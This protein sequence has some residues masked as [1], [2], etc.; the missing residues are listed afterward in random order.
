M[1]DYSESGVGMEIKSE[2]DIQFKVGDTVTVVLRRNEIVHSFE[3]TVK[4][5][6]KNILGVKFN[7]E[8]LDSLRMLIQITFSRADAWEVHPMKRDKE[9]ISSRL[10]SV[11]KIG[12][13]GYVSLFSYVHSYI[14]DNYPQMH[15]VGLYFIS[16]LPKRPRLTN[17]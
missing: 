17:N 7:D 16:F 11:L 5:A 3:T 4:F 10:L 6:S 14:K 2:Q 1:T 9:I 13:R 8:S 12:V 15:D